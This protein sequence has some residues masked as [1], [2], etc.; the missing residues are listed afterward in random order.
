MSLPSRPS[1]GFSPGCASLIPSTATTE[2]LASAPQPGLPV[3]RP[4]PSVGPPASRLPV[5]SC[6]PH[7]P[8]GFPAH[9]YDGLGPVVSRTASACLYGRGAEP[10]RRA[11]R[12]AAPSPSALWLGWICPLPVVRPVA[13]VAPPVPSCPSCGWGATV[14]G[15][16]RPLPAY[17]AQLRQ[18]AAAS[19]PP[20]A[21][22]H[23][24]P[25]SWVAAVRRRR[26]CH[27][28]GRTHRWPPGTCSPQDG[29]RHLGNEVMKRRGGVASSKWHP[30]PSASLIHSTPPRPSCVSG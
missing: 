8:A 12:R 4:P 27:S 7:S 10:A 6:G 13:G 18:R 23:P 26:G 20:P 29:G 15:G 11:G 24:P 22:G 30:P 9:P 17:P 21:S 25:S 1:R 2:R 28:G 16:W 5:P 19:P 3:C 14:L